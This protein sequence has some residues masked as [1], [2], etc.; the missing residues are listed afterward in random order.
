MCSP[1][2]KFRL[3]SPLHCNWY[4]LIPPCLYAAHNKGWELSVEGLIHFRPM[5]PVPSAHSSQAKSS[6]QSY[7]Y[8]HKFILT[9]SRKCMIKSMLLSSI[10]C[11]FMCLNNL[12][13][14]IYM[15]TCKFIQHLFFTQIKVSIS[16]CGLK[17]N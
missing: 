15:I 10:I 7:K 14:K 2:N 12:L 3:I 11:V 5:H 6:K 8:F 13:S 1:V 4:N 16:I 17:W 9:S